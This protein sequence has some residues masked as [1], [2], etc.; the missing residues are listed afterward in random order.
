M[1][2]ASYTRIAAIYETDIFN[3]TYY[4]NYAKGRKLVNCDRLVDL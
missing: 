2:H 3:A 4:Y 1:I